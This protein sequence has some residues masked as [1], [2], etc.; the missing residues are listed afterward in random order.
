MLLEIKNLDISYGGNAPTVQDVNISLAAGEVLAIVGESG[1]GKT[2]VIRAILGVLP[3]M[4]RI[5][6][7]EIT[8]AGKD[9]SQLSD[10]A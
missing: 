2:S 7:G 5:S 9:L 1:S 6:R 8:F 10:A 3:G 4:G